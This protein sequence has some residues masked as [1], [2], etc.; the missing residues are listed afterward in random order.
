MS[1]ERLIEDDL[2]KTT[3][4][5]PLRE[6]YYDKRV[7]L[8]SFDKLWR[9]VKKAG[10]NYTQKEVKSFLNRQ[11]STQLTK[12]FKKPRN[13][14][15]IRAPEPGTNLQMDLMFFAPKIKGKTGVLNVVDVHS[16]RAFSELITNKK[17]AT[18]K[19]AFEKILA[20]IAKDGKKVRHVNSDDGKEFVSVWKLLQD[21]GIQL[22]KSRKEEFAK[23]AIV[24]RF[25][26][27]VRNLM[28]KYEAEYPRAGLVED[29]DDLIGN[30]NE[31][32]HRTIK[33]E[34]QEVW[35]G[36]DKNKQDYKDIKYEFMKGD[37]VRVLYKKELF[38]KGTYGWEPQLYVITRILRTEDYNWLEQKHFV[39]PVSAAGAVGAE[40]P[41]WYMG[42]ELQKVEGVERSPDFDER[43]KKASE[44]QEEK[45]KAQAKQ[46]RA[47]AKE[48]L[49][50]AA[51]STRGR[52][53]TR[54]ENP[55]EF[56]GMKVQI[57]WYSRGGKNFVLTKSAKDRGS[58]GTF[59]KGKLTS[60]DQKTKRFRI[61]YEDGLTDTINLMD[62]KAKDYV[63]PTSWKRA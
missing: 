29:W 55:N 10:L 25:N 11:Q 31:S 48:G 5:E 24:E 21:N 51:S 63:P 30:Y 38:E 28:R 7:G 46:K 50:D 37:K 53:K 58:E 15:T 56:V 4:Y 49:D 8:T 3:D 22:H 2:K 47:L 45:K 1:K 9:K 13:F 32:Y 14:T 34:P 17:E 41:D 54:E 42:Y 23:N 43:K 26:R 61:K 20:E 16:R 19:K 33:A 59:Y 40:K 27:T 62:P 44:A 57:K 12:E 18:V 36:D 52:K 39:A 35:S 60:Y 6:I